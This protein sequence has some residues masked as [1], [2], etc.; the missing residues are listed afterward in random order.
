MAQIQMLKLAVCHYCLK[1]VDHFNLN[2]Q[3]SLDKSLLIFLLACPQFYSSFINRILVPSQVFHG[4][5]MKVKLCK[6]QQGDKIYFR[7]NTKSAIS[8]L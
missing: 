8:L 2:D 5:S 3:L 6:C 1:Y 7:G 4:I